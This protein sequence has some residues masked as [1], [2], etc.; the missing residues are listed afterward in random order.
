[1]TKHERDNHANQMNPN[2]DAYWQSRGFDERPEDFEDI[3]ETGK[4]EI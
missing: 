2:S 1:M 3:D 4:F